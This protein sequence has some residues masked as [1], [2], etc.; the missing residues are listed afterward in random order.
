MSCHRPGPT[1]RLSRDFTIYLCINLACNAAYRLTPS[2]CPLPAFLSFDLSV[3]QA[4]PSSAGSLFLSIHLNLPLSGGHGPSQ[5]DHVIPSVSLGDMQVS[6]FTP[7]CT[8]LDVQARPSISFPLFRSQTSRL[9]WHAKLSHAATVHFFLCFFASI[10]PS[11]SLSVLI[12]SLSAVCV[13]SNTVT[14]PHPTP[15]FCR[16]AW[17]RS[18]AS[19]PRQQKT[20]P[21]HY[22]A[23]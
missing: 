11:I 16:C 7:P 12:Q 1:S 4:E 18:T 17:Q 9:F 8:P 21:F 3:C 2:V 20:V 10:C 5:I 19:L 14:P 6:L 23:Y 15:P 13:C 22:S